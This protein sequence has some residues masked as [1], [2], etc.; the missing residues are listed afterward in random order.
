MEL[1]YHIHKLV[2]QKL[3]AEALTYFKQNKAQYKT[4]DIKSNDYLTSDMLTCLRMTNAFDAAEQYL[5]IYNIEIN[6]HT[7]ERVLTSWLLILYNWYKSNT[8]VENKISKNVVRKISQALPLLA[9]Q[10]SEFSSNFYNNIVRMVF[11]IESKKQQIDWDL[12]LQFCE[13][14][15]PSKLQENCYQVT[16][17]HKSEEKQSELASVREDW[18]TLYSKAL[19]ARAK[20]DKCI[21]ISKEA[22]DVIS[23]MHYSNDI[24]FSRRIAQCMGKQGNLDIAIQEFKKITKQKKDWFLLSELANLYHQNK[25]LPKALELMQNAMT[26]PGDINYKVELIENIGDVYAELDKK[27]LSRQHYQLAICIRRREDWKVERTLF[28]KSGEFLPQEDIKLIE[29]RLL[30]Q[31]RLEWNKSLQKKELPH[32]SSETK[33]RIQGKVLRMSLPKEAGIDIRIKADN[34]QQYYAFIRREDTIYSKIAI[35]LSISF[36]VIKINDKPL[37]KAIKIK[38]IPN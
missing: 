7:S 36:E 11:R 28:Q 19:Y 17:K 6:E 12:L 31:L 34:G 10:T 27:E 14:V 8:N 30:Q 38:Q 24:W 5:Q 29:S 4:D 37:D 9:I 26:K 22:L 18:Y 32:K 16:I 35:G 2:Q 21:E 33:Q 3:Y 25:N 23:K 15:E 13:S 1:Q 20:Y